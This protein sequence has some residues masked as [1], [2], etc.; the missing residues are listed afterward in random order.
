MMGRGRGKF[1]ASLWD[2]AVLT[3]ELMGS[4]LGIYLGVKGNVKG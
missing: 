3:R 2:E 1:Y 4:K